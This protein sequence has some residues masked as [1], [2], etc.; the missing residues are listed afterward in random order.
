MSAPARPACPAV[1]R[2]GR[3]PACGRCEPLGFAQRGGEVGA[4]G[5]GLGAQFRGLGFQGGDAARPAGA[6][7]SSSAFPQVNPSLRNEC[8]LASLPLRNGQR[9]T[10][11]ALSNSTGLYAVAVPPDDAAQVASR[12]LV[13]TRVTPD[14][15]GGGSLTSGSGTRGVRAGLL[16]AAFTARGSAPWGRDGGGGG[17][18]GT[19]ARQGPLAPFPWVPSITRVLPCRVR[20]GPG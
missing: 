9:V 19:P 11:A 3:V 8:A 18:A 4:E 15:E 17:D 13:I 2:A 10:A 12:L 20:N 6:P 5:F 1:D 7:R 14:A 16:I